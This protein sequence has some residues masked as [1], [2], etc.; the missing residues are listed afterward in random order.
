MSGK[1]SPIQLANLLQSQWQ[2]QLLLPAGLL[3]E[4][5]LELESLGLLD[6]EEMPGVPSNMRQFAIA[7]LKH[8]K[9]SYFITLDEELLDHRDELEN[10]YGMDILSVPEAIMLLRDNDGPPN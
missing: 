9:P 10:R 8:N 6:V 7:S 1:E 3:E 2:G 4:R 5:V